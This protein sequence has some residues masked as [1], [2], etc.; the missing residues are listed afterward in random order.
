MSIVWKS[1][2]KFQDIKLE[3]GEKSAQGIIKITI[4]RPKVRK[5][6]LELHS[7]LCLVSNL[8]NGREQEGRRVCR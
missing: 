7:G 4:N 2:K 1:I 6:L 3:K 5:I 8:N